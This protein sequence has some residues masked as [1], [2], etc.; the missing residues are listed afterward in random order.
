MKPRDHGAQAT[1]WRFSFALRLGRPEAVKTRPRDDQ[2]CC[3]FVLEVL[4]GRTNEPLV[5]VDSPLEILA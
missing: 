1:T 5:R 2:R 3:A 4:M